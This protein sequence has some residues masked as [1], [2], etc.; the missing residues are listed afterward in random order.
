MALYIVS[1]IGYSRPDFYALKYAKRTPMQV[2][3]REAYL[4]F[5]KIFCNNW[6]IRGGYKT[7]LI[8]L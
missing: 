6:V 5:G 4:G 1:L 7:Y 8:F 2:Q 3:Q